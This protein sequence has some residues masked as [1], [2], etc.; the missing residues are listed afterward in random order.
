MKIG[1][2]A[3]LWNETGVGRYI[4]NL[5]R[6]LHEID[7]SNEYILF[8]RNTDVERIKYEV[9]SNKWKIVSADIR[10][11]SLK[12]QLKFHQILN[13]ENLDLMHFTYFSVPLFYNRPFIVTIH[14]L[15][16]YHFQTGK[17]SSLPLP[18][19]KVKHL[20]Y[21]FLLDHIVKKSKKIIVP[22]NSTKLD[23]V[24]TL[25]VDEEKIAVTYEGV[26]EEVVDKP[27][28]MAGGKFNASSM[29]NESSHTL[30][31]KLNTK[32]FLYVGNAYPHKNL[33]TLIKA[34]I[35]LKRI[36]SQNIKLVLVGKPDYFYNKLKKRL[37]REQIAGVEVLE[38]V[39]DETLKKFYKRSTAVIAPAFIE[40]FGLVPLEAMANGS[41]V[42]VSDIPSHR[43]VCSDIPIY[44]NP[45]STQ[46]LIN[47]LQ[48]VLDHGFVDEKHKKMKAIQRI[49]EFSW[50][51]MAIETLK[52]YEQTQK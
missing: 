21:R 40:G 8:C 27:E 1:I 9:L 5:I 23:V 25:K 42:L 41:L 37:E 34:F 11:H 28:S 35:E 39:D 4:R 51:N 17:A 18:L 46:D 20:G 15:I 49:K 48:M 29:K 6:N 3:R 45:Y 43:E 36:Y 32:Y 7:L 19:Y 24:K 52:V 26:D 13:R 2:D 47:K 14:D 50:K 12:E 33:E 38:K 44:F 22:L 16:V 31:K 10:W 30:Y